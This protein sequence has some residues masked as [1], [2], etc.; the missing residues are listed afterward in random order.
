M[1]IPGQ[2]TIGVGQP[3]ESAN[4]DSLYT[5]FNKVNTNFD[6]LFDNSSPYSTFNAGTGIDITANANLGTVEITNLGV[7][8]IIAGTD[9]VVDHSNGNVTISS[10][11]GG[12]GSGG[13]VTSIGV[14]PVSNARLVVTNSPIVAS[15]NITIDLANSSVVPGIYTNPTLSVDQYGRV[16]AAS[17][18]AITGTV[19]SVGLAPGA[20]I[21]INGGPITSTGNIT[22][23]NIGVVRINAGAGIALS[24][25]NGNVTISATSTGGTVTSVA[26]TSGQLVIANSPITTFGTITVDLPTNVSITGSTTVGTFLKLTPGTQPGS[27]SEGMVYYDSATHVLKCYNGTTWKTITMT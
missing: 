11:G 14:N 13:T 6:N 7:T 20:G 8:N 22:V 10:T 12:N 26:I 2:I 18:N 1:S 16:I 17:N 27:A 4:S 9:I 25:S 24:G 21:Q 3:N 5:A 23:T 19:T 15:G